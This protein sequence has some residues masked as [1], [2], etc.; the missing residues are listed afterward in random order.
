MTMKKHMKNVIGK[1]ATRRVYSAA[2]WVGAALA[3]GA[4]TMLSRRGTLRSII[5]K[6]RSIVQP[7]RQ[8]L[9]ERVGRVGEKN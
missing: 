1:K 6:G 3:V 9:V 5:D 8:L 7:D 4:G 2:P